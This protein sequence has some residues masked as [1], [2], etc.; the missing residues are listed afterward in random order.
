VASA[1]D[2]PSRS[3][4]AP[5]PRPAQSGRGLTTRG[6]CLLAGGVAA[7]ICAV[8]LDE[9]D[10]LRV[11]LLAILLP[12]LA[13][14]FTALRRNQVGVEHQ[15][16]PERLQPG[17]H[18]SVTMVLRNSGAARTRSI[19]VAEAPT[20]GFTAGVRYLVPPIKGG[21]TTEIRYPF[22]ASRRG[23]F[24]LGPPVLRIYDPFD[25]WEDHRVLD[26]RTEVLVLPSLV[27]LIGMPR[28][29]GMRSAASGRA[30]FGAVGGDPDVGVRPYREGDDIRTIH[31]RASARYED[32]LVV[33]LDEPVSHGD[34]TL[35]IDHRADRHAGAGSSGS[36]ETAV[37]L[38]ASVALH[39]LA[40]DNELR[41]VD[42]RG[43]TLVEGHDVSDDVLAE[44][45]MIE[46][47]PDPAPLVPTSSGHAGLTLAVI[48]ELDPA[49]AAALAAS[50]GRGTTGMA[51]VLRAGE[52]ADR[53]GQ[54]QDPVAA[55]ILSAAGWRVVVLGRGDDLAAAWRRACVGESASRPAMADL[56]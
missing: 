5:A 25:L 28:G 41:L 31:W 56:R 43:H 27:P 10:L 16:F 11:G 18:G 29:S 46:P 54:V 13:V 19:D 9:R 55:R 17:S 32:E 4:R 7:A 34:T 6:R 42:H 24:V 3:R 15:V 12:V 40:T 26:V 47:D 39:L 45:A 49:E 38:T 14:L 50:R 8:V 53:P 30:A 44:L 33:R 21:H 23:R 22:E 35:L 48:G 20:A 51:F 36:L 1:A 2:G 37:T 52:W